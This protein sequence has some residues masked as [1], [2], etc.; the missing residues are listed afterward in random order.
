MNKRPYPSRNRII[1]VPLPLLLSVLSL[2]LINQSQPV[3]A[4]TCQPSHTVQFGENLYRIALKY[5]V[6]Q[7]EI[8]QLNGLANYNLI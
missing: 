2:W 7:Q 5:G 8:A 1:F 6:S 4:Q 3:T